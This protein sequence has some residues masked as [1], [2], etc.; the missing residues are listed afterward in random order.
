L[1]IVSF[2]LKI[3]RKRGGHDDDDAQDAEQEARA[4]AVGTAA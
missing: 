3:K 2:R 4:D 1:G